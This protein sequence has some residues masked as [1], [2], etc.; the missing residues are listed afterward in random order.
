MTKSPPSASAN[1]KIKNG[2]DPISL[3]KKKPEIEI[4]ESGTFMETSLN[5]DNLKRPNTVSQRCVI[6]LVKP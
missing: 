2:N 5:K 3:S 4:N 1:P 6:G